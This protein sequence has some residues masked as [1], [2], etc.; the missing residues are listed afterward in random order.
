MSTLVLEIEPI[1]MEVK[2]T[3]IEME[4]DTTRTGDAILDELKVDRRVFSF[5]SEF[6]DEEHRAYWLSRTPYERLRHL[7]LLRRINYGDKATAGLQRVLETA[8]QPSS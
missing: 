8:E 2:V 4:P 1:V 7:E 5:S 3:V 6:D